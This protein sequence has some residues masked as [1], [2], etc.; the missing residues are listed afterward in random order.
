[1][2]ENGKSDAEGLSA[3]TA[4]SEESPGKDAEKEKPAAA[5]IKISMFRD[6]TA[7]ESKDDDKSD[8]EQNESKTDDKDEEGD[9]S[10]DEANESKDLDKT[11]VITVEDNGED[12]P[13]KKVI[14]DEEF[15]DAVSEEEKAYYKDKAPDPDSVE[16]MNIH[17]TAC[18]EQV[19]HH[20]K[21][22]IT[23]HPKLGVPFCRKCRTFY[24]DEGE[25]EKDEQ[26]SES[27][28]R[29]CANGGELICCDKCTNSYCKRC[30]TRNLGRK[31][32]N[33]INDSETWNCFLCDP[34]PIYAMRALMYSISIWSSQRKARQKQKEK[35]AKQKKQQQQSKGKSSI[36]IIDNPDNFIDENINEAFDT[37]KIYQKCLEDE[38]KR[39]ANKKRVMNSE[40][41]A[42]VVSKLKKVYSI[43]KQNMELLE[44]TLLQSFKDQFPEESMG[45]YKSL[46]RSSEPVKVNRASVGSKPT[47]PTSNGQAKRKMKD[48]SHLNNSS[49]KKIKG[50][51]VSVDLDDD[52]DIAVE[53]IVMNGEAIMGSEE[54]FNP[55]ALC[56]VEITDG[57]VNKATKRKPPAPPKIRPNFK[58]SPSKATPPP[59]P[60]GPL[61]ISSNM[62]KKKSP[63]KKSPAKKSRPSTPDSDIVEILSDNENEENNGGG[64]GGEA[65]NDSDVSLE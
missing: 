11:D 30:I 50:G 13:T 61:R 35:E 56:S 53:E 2:A 58:N 43:T 27:Y 41:A 8:T 20:V 55:A 48:T 23:R 7:D 14:S 17:C 4:A 42:A 63:S 29:W 28:C 34:K 60:T 6:E 46:V 57:S 3:A 21:N 38:R 19:N 39:W 40:N 33:Q 25:W 18:G 62:F 9:K 32:F 54:Y 49:S 12:L 36:T 16:Q 51:V 1:M 31:M 45:K 37:L 5:G 26:G 15:Y 65:A 22:N 24:E 10:K 52:D 64:D 44:K 47:T 59:K